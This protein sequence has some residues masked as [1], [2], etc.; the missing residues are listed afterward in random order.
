MIMSAFSTLGLQGTGSSTL[1]WILDSDTSN[2]M[3]NSFGGLSNIRKF[4]GSSHIQTANDSALPIVA[5]G[6]IPPLKNIFVSLKLAINLAFVGQFV[7][8]NCDVYFSKHG[9]IVQDQMSGQLIAKGPKHKHLFFL[10]FH[11]PH[12]LAISSVLSLFY[13]APKMFNEVWHKCLGHPNPKI[14]S[15]LLKSRLINNKLHSSS[16]MFLDCVTCKLDKSK[17]LPFSL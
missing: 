11:V 15:H 6:D 9:C 10:Q 7:D 4:Y 2:H 8:N 1:S 16:S 3:K 14:L 5:V 13:T 17:V 12:T